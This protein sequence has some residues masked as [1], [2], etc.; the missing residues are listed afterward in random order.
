MMNIESGSYHGLNEVG[1]IIWQQLAQPIRVSQVC[2][3]VEQEFDVAPERCHADTLAF[4][5]KMLTDGLIK[6]VA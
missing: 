6:L 1:S 5:N 4:L 2:R 3:A